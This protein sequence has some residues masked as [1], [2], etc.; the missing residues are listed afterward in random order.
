MGTGGCLW[1]DTRVGEDSLA[2]IDVM[3][4]RSPVTG[5]GV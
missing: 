3:G 5:D 2:K 1:Q 4:H